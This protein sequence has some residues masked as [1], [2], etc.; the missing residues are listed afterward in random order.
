MHILCNMLCWINHVDI[1]LRIHL[2]MTCVLNFPGRSICSYLWE[3]Y[4][5]PTLLCLEC[6]CQLWLTSQRYCWKKNRRAMPHARGSVGGVLFLA[7][8]GVTTDSTPSWAALINWESIVDVNVCLVQCTCIHLKFT[9]YCTV[10]GTVRMTCWLEYIM[11]Q[12]HVHIVMSIHI[13][14][15]I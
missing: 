3:S 14:V 7:Y 9:I 15:C 1:V 6:V 2:R 11:E 12:V 4:P 13:C 5:L 8:Q 10:I